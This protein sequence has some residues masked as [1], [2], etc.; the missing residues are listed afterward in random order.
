MSSTATL[1]ALDA[2]SALEWVV[3]ASTAESRAAAD[4][5]AAMLAS[6]DMR[7]VVGAHDI[8]AAWPAD[9][10]LDGDEVSPP[11]SGDG[12]PQVTEDAVHE[13][14]A[15]LGI[16]HHATLALVGQTLELR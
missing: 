16:S 5:L 14:S 9:P 15:A 3:A 4:K 13:L 2:K 1:L 10:C 8:P 12:C 11:L 7:P 6:C